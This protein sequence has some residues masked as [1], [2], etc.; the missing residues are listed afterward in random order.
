MSIDLRLTDEIED[1]ILPILNIPLIEETLENATDV[2]TLDY[3]VYTDFINHKRRWEH[4]WAYL[5]E[6]DYN[7]VRGFYDRQ[8]TEYKYPLLSIDYYGINLVPV[9]MTIEPKNIINGCGMVQ[10]VTISLR[11]T[12]NQIAVS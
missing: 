11:E 6:D 8:F 4:T 9:R 2:I 5:S 7:K 1:E 12:G 3:N 10:D